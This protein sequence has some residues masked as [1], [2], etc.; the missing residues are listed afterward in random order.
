[1]DSKARNQSKLVQSQPEPFPLL[2][3]LHLPQMSRKE[4]TLSEAVHGFDTE[5]NQACYIHTKAP[6]FP[7]AKVFSGMLYTDHVQ[8]DHPISPLHQADGKTQDLG[9]T[10]P[11][12]QAHGERAE[13]RCRGTATSQSNEMLTRFPGR[14][15][16]GLSREIMQQQKTSIGKPGIS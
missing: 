13:P 5:P 10:P 9:R 14:P 7:I 15:R 3:T 2:C 12:Q 16:Q 4:G 8:Q 11:D 1:M 6:T